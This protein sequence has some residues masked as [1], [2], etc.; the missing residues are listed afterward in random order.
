MR[1]LPSLIA[2][3][4]FEETARH[5]S[6][7]RAASAL[8]VTQAAVSKQIRL[9]EASLGVELFERDHTGIRLTLAGL[10]LM[11]YIT[12]S[13]DLIECGTRQITVEREPQRLVASLPPTF[14]TQW[15]PPRIGRLST[16]L[17]GVEFSFRTQPRDA[18]HCVVRF[19]QSA[20][21]TGQSQLLMAE[22]DTLVVAACMR[23]QNVPALFDA[24][25]ALHVLHGEVRLPLWRD[26]LAHADLP[27]RYA[28]GGIEVSNL[29]QAIETV[30]SGIGPAIIDL[31]MVGN[32]L[33]GGILQRVSEIFG[34]LELTLQFM[35]TLGCEPGLGAF[36][37]HS[38]SA[39]ATR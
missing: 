8:C 5:L 25:P 17:S 37:P 4:F 38:V 16:S 1:R 28:D 7:N 11:P 27:A 21:E 10:T 35:N 34:A 36:G 22:R 39:R 12:D 24:Q 32:E 18:C 29:R 31:H 20:L 15:L 14:A 6:F 23:D 30:K 26:W 19:G 3:R 2:L 33:A 9:L 13:F